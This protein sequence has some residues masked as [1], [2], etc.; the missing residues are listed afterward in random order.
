MIVVDLDDFKTINDTYGHE[1]GDTLLREVAVRLKGAIRQEDFAAR[2][3][4]DEFVVH[5]AAIRGPREAA[6]IAVSILDALRGPY[7]IG[8]VPVH[9]SASV[10]VT[11]STQADAARLMA[12]ADRAMYRAKQ[13]GRARVE[14]KL[15][16]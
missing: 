2:L 3:G 4:G 16:P 1:I 12:E 6:G 8:A 5:C 15:L 10:G 7:L 11:T 9:L 14:V 13:R